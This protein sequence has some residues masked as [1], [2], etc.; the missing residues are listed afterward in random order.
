M[1]RDQH[2]LEPRVLIMPVIRIVIYNARTGFLFIHLDLH[3]LE[4]GIITRIVIGIVIRDE[5][6]RGTLPTG[7]SPPI[8]VKHKPDRSCAAN[9]SEKN[10]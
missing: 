9:R 10:S 3:I 8:Q 2:I 4:P 7:G 5:P 1:L 6:T